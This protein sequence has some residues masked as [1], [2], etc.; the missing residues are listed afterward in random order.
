MKRPANILWAL[1]CLAVVILFAVATWRGWSP[2]ADGPTGGGS[3]G[4]NVYA[5]GPRHK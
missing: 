5:R 2:G 4:G 1:W 3:G